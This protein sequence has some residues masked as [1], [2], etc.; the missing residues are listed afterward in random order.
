M[1]GAWSVAIDAMRY[2]YAEQKPVWLEVNGVATRELRLD[3]LSDDSADNLRKVMGLGD[4]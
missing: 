1:R 2:I 3:S 4:A